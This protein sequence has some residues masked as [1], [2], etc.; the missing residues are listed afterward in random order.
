[1]SQSAN[2]P[3]RTFSIGFEDDTYNELP[4][5]EAV[6]KYFGTKH[7]VEVLKSD[8]TDLTE[9]LVAQF[10]EPF[11]DTSIFPTLSCFKIASREVKVVLSGDGGDELFAGYDTYLAE[12][13]DR[14]YGH[15][16][17]PLR[18]Q[19]LP[20]FAGWLPAAGG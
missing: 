12:K 6:A 14:Y 1:M 20:K 11:A 7:H 10:D 19:I 16:P 18:Q 15:L 9:Q 2:E 8:H 3:V 5:A 17:R 4:Y 13:L